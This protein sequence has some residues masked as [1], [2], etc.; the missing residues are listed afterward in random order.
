MTTITISK[1]DLK[2]TVR[3]AVENTM[4]KEFAKLR[5]AS[6]PYVN[7]TEQREIEKK[8]KK[9]TRDFIKILHARV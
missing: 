5:A 2:N 7:K 8:Y 6:L 4:R 9:P 3:Q 1:N